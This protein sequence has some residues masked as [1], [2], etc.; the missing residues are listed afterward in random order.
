L[1]INHFKSISYTE[2]V[3]DVK[4]GTFK[5]WSDG[6]AEIFGIYHDIS[7][8]AKIFE[9]MAEVRG[10]YGSLNGVYGTMNIQFQR[11]NDGTFHANVTG[12]LYHYEPS[13]FE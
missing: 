2:G 11:K 5:L 13:R 3:K 1:E 4:E 8:S 10:G 7:E 12:R 6:G 9:I